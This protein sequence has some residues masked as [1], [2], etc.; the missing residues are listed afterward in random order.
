MPLTDYSFALESGWENF[1]ELEKLYLEHWD[2][3]MARERDL[4]IDPEPLTM[5]LPRY[6]KSWESG[7]LLNYV[8]RYNPTNEAVGAANVYLSTDMHTREL[9]GI[10]DSLFVT[11]AHR[12]GVGRGLV[13]FILEDMYQRGVRRGYLDAA[14]DPRAAKQW[15]RMGFRPYSTRMVI[16]IDDY[17]AR[18]KEAA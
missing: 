4:G 10:E 11:K 9:I 13:K 18:K 7:H 1:P 2:E 3:H 17:A 5:N 14:T 6:R 8:A 12:K 15:E 16:H